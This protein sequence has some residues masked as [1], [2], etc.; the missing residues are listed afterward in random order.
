MVP[1]IITP[2]IAIKIIQ[3]SVIIGKLAIVILPNKANDNP[4]KQVIADNIANV[5]NSIVD[6]LF[7][8]CFT[9]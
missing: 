9:L 3:V 2:K 5:K 8:I 1:T 4:A 7:S 6:I